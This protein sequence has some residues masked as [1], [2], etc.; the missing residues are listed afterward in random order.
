MSVRGV[1]RLGLA[2]GL[3]VVLA[4]CLAV[5]PDYRR[6][7]LD[8]PVA[9]VDQSGRNQPAGALENVAWWKAFGDPVLDELIA[10]GMSGNL[11]IAQAR[12]R[13]LQARADVGTAK[14]GLFP[15]I[16]LTGSSTTSSNG[17]LDAGTGTTTTSAAATTSDTGAGSGSTGTT[18][19]TSDSASSTTTNTVFAAGFDA[20]WELD[21]F[22]GK[23]RAHEAAKASLEA[24]VEALNSARLT[25]LG[26]V[27]TYYVTLRAYQEQRDITRKSAEAQRQ[28][29]EVTRERYRLGLITQ[30]DVAQAEGEAASTAADIATL[31]SSV[32]QTIH[33]L[34]IL[35]GLPPGELMPLLAASRPLPTLS[36]PLLATGLPSELLARRPDVRKAERQLAAA[37]ANIGVAT[38]ELYPKFDLTAGL[39]LQGA[40]PS[41]I[42][43]FSNWYW[44]AI[45]GLSWTL[46]DAGS[47]RATVDKKK[48]LFDEA[49]ANYKATFH[50]ALED[51]ENALAAYYAEQERERL[52]T[53]SVRAYEDAVALANERY[54]KGL[55]TFLTV[56]VNEASLYTAQTN[57]SKSRANLR[58]D[59]VALYKALGGGWNVET[60]EAAN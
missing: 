57:L 35:L 16:S 40:S 26:D 34:G 25:L 24:S 19:G 28:N 1:V 10:R 29:A 43:G 3:T 11:D 36:G 41:R 45:P 6:P 7:E 58:T 51:V 59:V 55:T 18:S 9:W 38:A 23:R 20:S 17:S 13:V 8:A 37:S 48:A 14:A 27:A 5:G 31:D 22:G 47:A 44:S 33:R 60:A 15:S 12:A 39:G 30:L 21:F 53:A 42:A 52:L 2:A 32:K 56:L 49:L 50:T 4:G 46:F 54:V